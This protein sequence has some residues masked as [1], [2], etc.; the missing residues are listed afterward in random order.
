MPMYPELT[1]GPSWAVTTR[2]PAVLGENMAL[3]SS[4]TAVAAWATAALAA[5]GKHDSRLKAVTADKDSQSVAACLP[6]WAYVYN[7]LVMDNNRSSA[8][9]YSG[10]RGSRHQDGLQGGGSGGLLVQ[11]IKQ[12]SLDSLCGS[13]S[14][15]VGTEGSGVA[16]S[17]ATGVKVFRLFLV[18]RSINLS[19]VGG[20]AS[21]TVTGTATAVGTGT[22]AGETMGTARAPAAKVINRAL[23]PEACMTHAWPQNATAGTS[24]SAG[25]MVVAAGPAVCARGTHYLSLLQHAQWLRNACK[26]VG[27]LPETATAGTVVVAGTR[28]VSTG[29][30]A[31]VSFSSSSFRS[32]S[33][34]VG[35]E[36]AEVSS[37]VGVG[38][39]KVFRGNLVTRLSS[40]LCPWIVAVGVGAGT[41]TVATGT[42]S[43]DGDTTL[44][45]ELCFFK[46]DTL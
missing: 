31:G 37:G 21:A 41:R 30:A 9:W 36:G 13:C 38:V 15:R 44:T 34:R 11:Q 4:T 26:G 33:F 22:T 43:G 35:T 39:E 25:T 27:G 5:A 16:S 1:S 7:K 14:L 24:A 10:N 28:T 3:R 2:A 45:K 46:S 32:S 42:A 29:L 17:V 23:Q 8:L 19:C 18:S 20:L 12:W 40:S 6:P